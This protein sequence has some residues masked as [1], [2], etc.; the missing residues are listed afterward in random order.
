ML[1][2]RRYNLKRWVMFLFFIGLFI[3]CLMAGYVVG[4]KPMIKKDN[5]IVLMYHGVVKDVDKHLSEEKLRE[6]GAGIYDVFVEDFEAH[7]KWIVNN[8]YQ[9]IVDPKQ[10]R[11]DKD[12]VILTFDDGGKE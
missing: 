1:E 11:P 10:A 9:V 2:N 12:Y 4:R 3:L 8:G 7:L 6:V 5:I